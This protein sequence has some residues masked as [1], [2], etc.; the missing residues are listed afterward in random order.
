[1]KI[2]LNKTKLSALTTGP[3]KFQHKPS[4]GFFSMGFPGAIGKT[5]LATLLQKK[6]SFSLSVPPR[7]LASVDMSET[8]PSW[9]W[10]YPNDRHENGMYGETLINM[11][12]LSSPQG[13]PV[14]KHKTKLYCAKT[15]LARIKSQMLA[16]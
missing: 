12:K 8:P 16:T 15:W 13:T 14:P 1:M 6:D 11:Q 5:K 9:E 3:E 4:S 2:Y 7:N 10:P